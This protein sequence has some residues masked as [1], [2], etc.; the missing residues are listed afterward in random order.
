MDTER[1]IIFEDKAMAVYDKDSALICRVGPEDDAITFCS[2]PHN[3]EL[4]EE[5]IELNE[6]GVF[7]SRFENDVNNGG[8]NT[9]MWDNIS[10]AI[11]HDEKL[12]SIRNA[13]QNG[14]KKQ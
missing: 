14:D 2:S 11:E 6:I 10:E 4:S 13:L 12:T 1:D 3:E 9:V 5:I 8:I 7:Y